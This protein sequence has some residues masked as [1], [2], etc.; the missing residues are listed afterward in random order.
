MMIN[1]RYDQTFPLD[2]RQKALFELL[3]ADPEQKR[4]VLFDS[5]HVGYPVSQERREIV[6][7]LD[8]TLGPV[9]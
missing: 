3:G 9:H 4:H 8:T 1:G 5:G 7:W 2:S 6:A